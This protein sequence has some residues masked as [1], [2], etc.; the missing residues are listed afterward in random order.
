MPLSP[1]I[2]PELTG[3][4]CILHIPAR[5]IKRPVSKMHKNF[6]IYSA[7]SKLRMTAGV[8]YNEIDYNSVP[9][10][11]RIAPGSDAL[12][13]GMLWNSITMTN[14]LLTISAI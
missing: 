8:Q 4:P 9:T 5:L 10:T 12:R 1:F 13:K 14:R 3:S 11:N 6:R 7:L 2:M